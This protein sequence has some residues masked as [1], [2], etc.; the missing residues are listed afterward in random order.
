MER[1]SGEVDRRV[2][3][4]DVKRVLM[5]AY[6]FPPVRFQ[7]SSAHA[8]VLPRYLPEY[9]WEPM[10]LSVS[11]LAYPATDV[12]QLAEIPQ[13]NVRPGHRQ[14]LG[15]LRSLSVLVSAA[16]S[17]G[18]LVCQRYCYRIMSDSPIPPL[19]VMVYLSHRDRACDRSHAASAQ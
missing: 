14:A 1:S 3:A 11:P 7:R 9:G 6:H 18:K 12:G 17:L 16:G 4:A 10:V 8:Q 2:G 15:D 19:V 5:I 13:E